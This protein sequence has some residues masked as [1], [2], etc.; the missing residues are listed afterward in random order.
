MGGVLFLRALMETKYTR[1]VASGGKT[2]QGDRGG[3]GIKRAKR[4][5][6]SSRRQPE[7]AEW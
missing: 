5:D 4:V 2:A 1:Q 6:R 7:L 3:A